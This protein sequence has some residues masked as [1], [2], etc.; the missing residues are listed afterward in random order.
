M[1][2]EIIIRE[3]SS[4]FFY[5]A[6]RT[7]NEKNCTSPQRVFLALLLLSPGMLGGGGAQNGRGEDKFRSLY[8][9]ALDGLL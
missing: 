9:S 3:R 1:Y 7:S 5:L 4:L 8:F 6:H 2:E